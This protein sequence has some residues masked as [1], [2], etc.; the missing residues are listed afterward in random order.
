MSVIQYKLIPLDYDANGTFDVGFFRNFTEPNPPSIDTIRGQ[1]GV[2]RIPLPTIPGGIPDAS[3]VATETFFAFNY[4]N[5]NFTQLGDGFDYPAFA[6]APDFNGDSAT[7]HVFGSLVFQATTL[8]GFELATWFSQGTSPPS[9]SE[10]KDPNGNISVVPLE[11]GNPDYYIDTSTGKPKIL[12]RSV[13]G[14]FNGD[15]TSDILF[16]KQGSTA[17]S[18]DVGTWLITA[19]QVASSSDYK[20]IAQNVDNWSV[21]NTND[22]NGDSTTDIYISRSNSDG[23]TTIGIWLMN[24]GSLQQGNTLPLNAPEGWL[25]IDTNNFDAVHKDTADILF[26]KTN[27]DSTTNVGVWV[28]DPSG[29]VSSYQTI[30]E[31]VA[32]KWQILDHNDF[33]GDGIA[34]ILIKAENGTADDEYGFWILDGNGNIVS[35][36]IY[37]VSDSSGYEFMATGDVNGDSKADIVLVKGSGSTTTIAHWLMDGATIS[38]GYDFL[39]YDSTL[40]NNQPFTQPSVSLPT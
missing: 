4:A 39:S 37:T 8:S 17:T 20:T 31:N 11:W 5:G 32:S 30:A 21:F 27:S 12:G 40:W 1:V 16:I 18:I 24:G 19:G 33:N 28:L 9:P 7:D 10:I 2:W 25:P 15:G 26:A 35:N 34:D 38:V 3:A 13:F 23:T 6:F 22:A 14:D 29:S 36:S